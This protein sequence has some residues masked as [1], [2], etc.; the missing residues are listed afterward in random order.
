MSYPRAILHVDGDSFFVACE[1]AKDPSL[2]FRPVVTG[3]ERGIASALSYEAKS[4]GV[5]RG[6]P[7]SMVRRICPDVVVLPSDYDTYQ[8]YSERMANI[9]RRYA[10]QVEWYSI[11]ECF[12]DLTGLEESLGMSYEEV[13]ARIKRD[14]YDELGITFSVGLSTT[15]VLAKVAS[16]IRKPNGLTFIPQESIKD[17]L[18]DVRVGKVWGV[19]SSTT[20]KM[21]KLGIE[22]ALDLAQKNPEW[23]QENF[24]KPTQEI[25][26]ELRGESV[27]GLNTEKKESYASISKTRSFSP[28]RGD[29]AFLLSELSRNI[30]NACLKLRQH[31]LYAGKIS[32]FLKTKNFEYHTHEVRLSRA[33]NVPQVFLAEVGKEFDRV[34]QLG[35]FYR[36]TGATLSE[37]TET[38]PVTLDLFGEQAMREKMAKAFET[39]DEIF[40]KYGKYSVFLASSL[41]SISERGDLS[42]DK[43]GS[44][45]K[46]LNIPYLGVVT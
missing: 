39:V 11:D 45:K 14:L 28:A 26:W 44:P 2:R 10:P 5:T 42:A 24:A 15:K 34:F 13:A 6:L 27:M 37:I 36:T 31:G 30:E 35:Y 38:D 4:R 19:G 9:I 29:K 7:I 16:K 21:N 40:H 23:V 32:F 43:A 1:V 20:V 41:L 3:S 12:A 8:I 18:K 33:S 17:F 25:F 22:T 46:R